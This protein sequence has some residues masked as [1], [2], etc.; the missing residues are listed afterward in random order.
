LREVVSGAGFVEVADAS[1]DVLFVITGA[2]VAVSDSAAGVP[3]TLAQALSNMDNNKIAQ[4]FVC[5]N[6]SFVHIL[7]FNLLTAIFIC[8]CKDVHHLAN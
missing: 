5:M 1:V 2:G 3:V 8:I 4:I 7:P 6:Y